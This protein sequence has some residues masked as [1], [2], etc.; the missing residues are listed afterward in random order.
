MIRGRCLLD[1]GECT[2]DNKGY[3]IGDGRY[4]TRNGKEEDV[5]LVTGDAPLIMVG[6]PMAIRGILLVM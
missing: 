5:S 3:I 4:T 2:T 1:N 6:I